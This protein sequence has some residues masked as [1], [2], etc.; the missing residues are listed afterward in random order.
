[1]NR[2]TRE[3]ARTL[4]AKALEQAGYFT[5]K[6]AMSAGYDYSHL[7]YHVSTGSFERVDHG[8]YR[9]TSLPVGEN[10]DLIRL[11]LWSRNRQDQPQAV[12]SHE[13]ALVLH[14]LTEILP[15]FVHLT[16]PPRFRKDPPVGCVLH[17][18]SLATAD[19][20]ERTGFRVTTPLRTLVDVATGAISR[21]QLE[22]AVAEA[23]TRGLVRR[24]KLL[25]AA[26]KDPRLHRIMEIL[27][28]SGVNVT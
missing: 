6:Q 7:D 1:M 18:A 10:N 17:K 25:T 2:S 21:E 4:L 26:R 3:T 9:L 24:T 22:K 23:L 13:S 5:A 14:D 11:S 8:L 16:V 15:G 19:V 27:E 20:E 12:V 28:E